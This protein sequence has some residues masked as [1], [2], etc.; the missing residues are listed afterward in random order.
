LYLRQGG[1]NSAAEFNPDIGRSGYGEE[2]FPHR[3][4]YL[5]EGGTLS[6]AEFENAIGRNT[7]AAEFAP[8]IGRNNFRSG[9]CIGNR[10][11]RKL[12]LL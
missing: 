11:E 10:E 5:R 4:L 6:A 1:T 7:L 12:Y 8:A 9:I 3:D 2:Q